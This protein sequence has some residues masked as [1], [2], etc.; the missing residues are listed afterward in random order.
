VVT[1]DQGDD[2]AHF[3][4]DLDHSAGIL[5]ARDGA[6]PAR[7]TLRVGNGNIALDRACRFPLCKLSKL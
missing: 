6:D 1:P 3:V 4:G 2:T 5:E 7:Q